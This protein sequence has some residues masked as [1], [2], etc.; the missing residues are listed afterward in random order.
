MSRLRLRASSDGKV[1]LYHGLAKNLA[2]RIAWHADQKLSP[3]SLKSGFLSTFRF[4]LLA[5]NDFPYLNG[6]GEINGYFDNLFVSWQETESRQEAQA[7][8]RS[9]LR[10][11]YHY[12]LNILGNK[13]PELAPFVRFLQSKRKAYKL[14][15]SA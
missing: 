7:L 3:S 14:L 6:S 9:E 1:C 2:Q 4:T 10:R 12:P 13:H 15:H 5:L 8:E 11:G